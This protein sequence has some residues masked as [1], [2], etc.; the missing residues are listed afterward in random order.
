MQHFGCPHPM[1]N[2]RFSKKRLMSTHFNNFHRGTIE[3]SAFLCVDSAQEAQR[4]DN[5]NYNR[6]PYR[7]N[8]NDNYSATTHT[9]F[10]PE[11]TAHQTQLEA[12]HH[13][14]GLTGSM[15]MQERHFIHKNAPHHSSNYKAI[16]IE[17][18][19]HRQ[20]VH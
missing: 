15:S 4:D 2:E 17:I 5:S 1:C 16:I 3:S 10:Y 12:V 20:R 18:P 8:C 7:T 9:S 14:S 11:H 6:K 13:L 19:Y